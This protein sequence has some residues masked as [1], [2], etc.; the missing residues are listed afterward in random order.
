MNESGKKDRGGIKKMAEKMDKP[1]FVENIEINI[2][3]R[4]AATTATELWL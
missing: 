2:L 3:S 1:D 4:G